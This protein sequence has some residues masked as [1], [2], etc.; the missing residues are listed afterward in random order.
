MKYE[1]SCGCIVFRKFHGNIELLL[2]KHLNSENWCFPKGHMELGETEKETA[3]R[4]VREET[5]IDVTVYQ[6]F[7]ECVFF[8][9]KKDSYKQVVYFLAK[10]QNF[11]Y[12]AQ[13]DEIAQVRWAEI[14]SACSLLTYENDKRLVNKAKN[15][16]RDY[17]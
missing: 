7:R 1:K 2:I 15:I 14:H 12:V 4:E 16:I 3:L 13:E 5:G 17:I 10:A 9:V 8:M 11:E 6:D